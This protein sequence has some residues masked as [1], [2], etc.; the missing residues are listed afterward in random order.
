M[1]GLSQREAGEVPNWMLAAALLV[2]FAIQGDLGMKDATCQVDSESQNL[3]LPRE[4]Y[5]RTTQGQV[6]V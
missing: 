4:Y 3:I 6:L 5:T 2:E 1:V